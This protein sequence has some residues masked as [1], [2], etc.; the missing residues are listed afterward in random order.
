[1][2]EENQIEGG[3][4]FPSMATLAEHLGISKSLLGIAK[5]KGAPG[6]TVSGRV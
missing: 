5:R 4:V 3:R 2:A 6:F 1:M